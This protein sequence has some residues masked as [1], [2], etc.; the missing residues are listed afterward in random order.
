MMRCPQ[1]PN[2]R[3]MRRTGC[4]GKTHITQVSSSSQ[5]I[6]QTHLSTP[7]ASAGD[8]AQ[9]VAMS[10]MATF[11]GCGSAHMPITIS[12]REWRQ[13]HRFVRIPTYNGAGIPGEERWG[14]NV[15]EVG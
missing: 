12:G 3:Q 13:S 6:R 11:S 10:R 2:A 5:L 14:Y 7:F 1:Q 15:L 4:G 8:I 9:S